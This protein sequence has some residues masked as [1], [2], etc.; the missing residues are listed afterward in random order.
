MAPEPVYEPSLLDDIMANP[1]LLAAAG[2]VLALLAG[3]GVVKSRRKAQKAVAEEAELFQQPDLPEAQP[4]FTPVAGLSAQAEGEGHEPLRAAPRSADPLAEAETYSSYGRFTQ[5]AE[6]LRN[7]LNDEPQRTDLRLKLMEVCAEMGDRDGFVRQEAELGEI[8]GAQPQIDQLRARYP[9]ILATGAAIATGA[10]LAGEPEEKVAPA[11][12][13]EVEPVEE[14]SFDDFTLDDLSLDAVPAAAPLAAGGAVAGGDEDFDLSLD[15]LEAE[16]ERELA[17]NP[18]AA[19]EAPLQLDELTL[20]D[21]G[22]DFASAESKPAL[23][24]EQDLLAV[25]DAPLAKAADDLDFDLDLE[26]GLDAAPVVPQAQ[27]ED[28][29]LAELDQLTLDDT[30][31]TQAAS[32]PAGSDDFAFELDDLQLPA[33][34]PQAQAEDALL[35]ELDQLALED[36][37]V[38]QAAS[39]SAGSDDFAFDLDDLQLPASDAAPV[40]PQAQAQAEEEFLLD[41]PDLDLAESTVAPVAQGQAEP[42]ADALPGLDD[43]ELDL[44]TLN[45]GDAEQDLDAAFDDFLAQAELPEVSPA[46]AVA[47]MAAAEAAPELPALTGSEDFDFLADS[48]ETATK[49]DLARAYIDMGDADGARDILDEV[50]KEGNASQQQEAREMLGRIA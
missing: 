10:A 4:D 13:A 2:G 26:L 50:L 41:L 37:P 44:Q 45:A 31:M 11:A 16:L 48:D 28:E 15:D 43:L 8:G 46:P 19:V 35:A 32:T 29:L 47:P 30:P 38:T 24:Q 7:A 21:L 40:A 33:G 42:E 39:A 14:F 12:A 34:A 36:A 22:S 3:L 20:D 9:Q 25:E 18:A 1:L 49:L 6:V 17:A 5:A 23:G 27:A